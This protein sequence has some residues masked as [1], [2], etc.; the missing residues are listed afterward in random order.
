MLTEVISYGH[1][2]RTI[3]PYA[4]ALDRHFAG[5]SSSMWPSSTVILLSYTPL[6]QIGR[7]I[8][9]TEHGESAFTSNYS[10]PTVITVT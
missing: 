4:G 6:S 8:W 2:M 10:T 1:I 5:P 3:I 7:Y 9:L